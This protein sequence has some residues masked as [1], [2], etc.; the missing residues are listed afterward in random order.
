MTCFDMVSFF[1]VSTPLKNALADVAARNQPKDNKKSCPRTGQSESC[2]EYI[3]A[4]G[5]LVPP[6]ITISKIV[7]IQ[8]L[9]STF[10]VTP[11]L[12]PRINIG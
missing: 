10:R 6:K 4:S 2:P 3:V 11:M 9:K 1:H 8:S 7:I 12:I 5:V